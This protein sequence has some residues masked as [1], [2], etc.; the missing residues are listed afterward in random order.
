MV[1]IH[2]KK[3][4]ESLFLY[5]T[6][7]STPLSKLVPEIAEVHNLRLRLKRLISAGEDLIEYG[8]LKPENEQ[9]YTEEQL[10]SLSLK[11][12]EPVE[13]KLVEKNGVQV[14]VNL[15]P[16]G[17][18]TGDAPN[19]E[20][21]DVIRR[22]LN[23]AKACI[24][25]DQVKANQCLTIEALEESLSEVQGAITIVYP[26]GLPEWEPVR[27]ILDDNEDLSGTAASKE[28]V[29][30]DNASLWWAG[31]EMVRE[32]LLSDFVGKN[33]KTKIVAK[34]QKVGVSRCN[35]PGIVHMQHNDL[36]EYFVQKGQGPP[37]REPPLDENGQKQMMA[38]W[39]RKQEENKVCDA[40][41]L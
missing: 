35:M 31:K 18:R 11:D 24:S 25:A 23:N 41:L 10:E 8:P 22:T 19:E 13:K 34:I 7:A 9:G 40:S 32:K 26:M 27:E 6:P 15:D 38:Y 37:I 14:L 28:I 17:R 36:D 1:V 16:T 30:P 2:L 20:M 39:Y 21:A 4:E 33:D 5:E 12:K 29:E 3:A